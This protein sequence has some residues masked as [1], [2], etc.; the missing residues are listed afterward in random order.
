MAIAVTS[1]L[2]FL[3]LGALFGERG[4]AVG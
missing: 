1:G 3:E 4:G 2:K